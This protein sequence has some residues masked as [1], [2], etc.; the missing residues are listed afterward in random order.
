MGVFI[1]A[2]HPAAAEREGNNL[3]GFQLFCLENGSSQGHNLALTV[4]CVT[5]SIN[6]GL[7]HSAE[8]PLTLQKLTM[9]VLRPR[10]QKWMR[11]V[12]EL[13]GFFYG[14]EVP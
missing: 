2:R 4:L 5:G 14:P 11:M 3:N 7:A 10:I 6:N 12:R 13:D 1:W 9:L 8:V